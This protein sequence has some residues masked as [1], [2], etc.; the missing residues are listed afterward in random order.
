MGRSEWGASVVF[1]QGLFV[2]TGFGGVFYPSVEAQC[3]VWMDGSEYKCL[4]S[5]I[6]K[7]LAKTLWVQLLI[8]SNGDGFHKGLLLS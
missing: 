6:S 1:R 3:C 8:Q 5:K 4:E 2:I 7:Y